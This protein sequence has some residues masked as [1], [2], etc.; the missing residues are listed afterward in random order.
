M[1]YWIP[2]DIK[3][4]ILKLYELGNSSQEIKDL[5][6]LDVHVRS[7]QRLVKRAGLSRTVKESFNIAVQKGRV[8]YHYK[9]NKIKRITLNTKRRF[10][11]LRR[12]NFRCVLCGN[13]ADQDIIN[14]DH[15]N[16][17]K[18]DSDIDNLQTLCHTCNVGKY[19]AA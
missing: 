11:V 19:H 8:T 9:P 7:I 12:D 14:V 15:I 5:L 16:G 1:R 6:H 18:N 2:N 13:T 3:P 10:E 17:D 4:D